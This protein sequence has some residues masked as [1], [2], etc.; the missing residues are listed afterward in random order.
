[1]TKLPSSD[2]SH[3][4]AMVPIYPITDLGTSFFTSPS[5]PFKF[6]EQGP[7]GYNADPEAPEK[8]KEFLD[9]TSK[10]VTNSSTTPYRNLLYFWAQE[11]AL[12]PELVYSKEQRDKGLMK[13]T[14]VTGFIEN[15]KGKKD[16]W[17]P[18]FMIHGDKD[19]AVDVEQAREVEK[20][21]KG[22]GF[23]ELIYEERKGTDQLSIP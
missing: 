5:Q 8:F 1:M 21:L 11:K 15:N 7:G 20:S 4:K 12:F 23:N 3:I 14:S 17:A 2:L 16:S 10:V 19:M 13:T 6:G 9:P 18:I 22:I